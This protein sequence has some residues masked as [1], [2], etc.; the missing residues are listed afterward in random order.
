MVKR[1]KEIGI[2]KVLGATVS[3]ILRLV[4]VD[5]LKLVILALLI[6]LPISFFVLEKWLENFAYK[7]SVQLWVFFIAGAGMILI[8]FITI[9][10]QALR[11]AME[12][13]VK[14][15]RWE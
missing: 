11:T 13:P 14:S 3:D 6:A 15:L 7:I 8:A 2:R 12:K 10:M 1:T 9:S 4:S 5:F